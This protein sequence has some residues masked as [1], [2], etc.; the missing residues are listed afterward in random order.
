M[1]V[2]QH[3]SSV[4]AQ[5]IIVS[6]HLTYI[7]LF[8]R[9][10]DAEIQQNFMTSGTTIVD[11]NVEDRE[12]LYKHMCI[13]YRYALQHGVIKPGQT[14]AVPH[15]GDRGVVFA[16]F[17][18]EDQEGNGLNILPCGRIENASMNQLRMWLKLSALDFLKSIS[19]FDVFPF[20]RK[21]DDKPF[22]K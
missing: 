16:N 18:V 22:K 5:H 8:L 19:V 14:M 3:L 6:I 20:H 21:W 17:P 9:R 4:T 1:T 10:T 15:V 12:M 7:S 11:F 2:C 13:I